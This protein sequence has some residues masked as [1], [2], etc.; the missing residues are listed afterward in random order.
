MI[1]GVIAE[2]A[3]K[4]GLI[5]LNWVWA[6]QIANTI[7]LFLIL[8]KLLFK[9]VTEFMANREKEISDQIDGAE[10]LMKDA[11]TLMADYKKKISNT[12][13][14][15][16]EIIRQATR[17]AEE[18]ASHIIKEAEAQIG[19]MKEKATKEIERERIKAVNSLKDEIASIAVMAASKVIEKD[20]DEESHKQLINQ[21]ISE[22]G[23][24]RWQS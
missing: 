8:K 5:E 22:V 9:P 20:I 3:L 11:E 1:I 24:T 13:E 7:I 15:G 17:K 10:N 19:D 16:R 6:T 4:F 12:E 14:E 2:S 23:D 18:R 21:F